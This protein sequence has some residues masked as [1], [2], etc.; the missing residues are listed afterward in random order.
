MRE[1][2]D[3]EAEQRKRAVFDS[4]S[5]RNQ[6]R[7]LKK[8]YDGWNPFMEPKDPIDIRRDKTK[9]TS[10]SL[11][12]EFLQSWSHDDYSNEF[13]RGAFELCMG[14]INEDEKSRG[15]LAFANWYRELL[16]REGFDIQ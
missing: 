4:M 12:R 3:A 2:S 1:F 15:M 14:I 13:A 6:K 5:P 10:Q 9:R 11:I 16:E 8:G 7:I